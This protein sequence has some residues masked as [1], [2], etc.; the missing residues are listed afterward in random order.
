M[1]GKRF[2]SD[3]SVTL[4][5]LSHRDRC[6]A[7]R[8]I[9]SGASSAARS[10]LAHARVRGAHALVSPDHP[11]RDAASVHVPCHPDPFPCAS[12]PYARRPHGRHSA[13]ASTQ[14]PQIGKQQKRAAAIKAWENGASVCGNDL[15]GWWSDGFRCLPESLPCTRGRRVHKAFRGHVKYVTSCFSFADFPRLSV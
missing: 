13:A 12:L 7:W 1:T 4:S 11:V 14:M 5:D 3:A 9:R 6:H 15:V 8:R 10:G 2:W